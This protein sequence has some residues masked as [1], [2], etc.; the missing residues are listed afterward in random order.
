MWL[1]RLFL[2][3]FI[4]SFCNA[5]PLSNSLEKRKLVSRQDDDGFYRGY[6]TF[7]HPASEGGPVGSCGPYEDDDSQIIALNLDQY[8]GENSKSEWCFKKLL[9]TYHDK[10]TV[11]TITDACPGC[12]YNSLDLTPAVFAELEDFSVGVIDIA[13]CVLGEDGCSE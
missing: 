11:A 9:I 7:F 1:Y 10:S 8:G 3:S 4:V 13:W 12:S 2:L 5:L 6:G